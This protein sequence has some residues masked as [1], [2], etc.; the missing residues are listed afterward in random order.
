MYDM[1]ANVKKR[2]QILECCQE[3]KVQ[4]GLNYIRDIRAATFLSR[5]E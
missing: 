2:C 5:S 1:G 4:C 3:D